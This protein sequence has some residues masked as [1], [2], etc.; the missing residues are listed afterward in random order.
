P[1]QDT[2]RIGSF[3]RADQSISFQAMQEKYEGFIQIIRQDPAVEAVSGF[4]GG[5]GQVNRGSIFITLKPLSERQT[6]ARDVVAR[7]QRA[8][9]KEPGARLTMMPAQDI[10]IGGRE[11]TAE[12]QYTLQADDIGELRTWEPQVRQ[13]LRQLPQITD[14][15]S[16]QDDRGAQTMLTIDRDAVARLGL[17]VAQVTA[18]LNDAFGQRQVSTI[19]NP[20]NQYQV[21]MTAA[22]PFA[23]SAQSLQNIY[24]VGRDGSRVPLSA[25]ASYETENTALSVNHQGQFVTATFSFNLAPGVALSEAA[26]AVHQAVARTGLP[27]S[28]IGSLQGTAGAFEKM[29]ATQVILILAALVVV[30]LV[31]GILYESFVHPLTI[32]STLPSAGIGALLAIEL[33][34]KDF[35]LITLL[36]VLLLIGLVMKNAIMMVDFALMAERQ[37]RMAPHDAIFT[38]CLLRF[39][40]IM[41]TTMTA[42][43]AALPL[44]LG[45]GDG[46]EL[47]QPLGLA[48][49]GGL[50]VSQL[51]TLY[52]TPVVYLYIYRLRER[53][54]GRKTVTGPLS[55]VEV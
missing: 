25:V 4:I 43:F 30:Y 51:L 29:A 16:D 37:Q 35:N 38:A 41:M 9:S 3:I 45:R 26:E 46:A 31:L 5:G 12:Y 47:R 28:V 55:S 22:P 2:G 13:A 44:M 39:R 15:D 34:G 40:P 32:L 14:V 53:L 6:S 17:T 54:T 24:L 42:I 36:G 52:T 7:L 1:T 49:V 48:I 21:V 18:A 10:R 8:L 50:L 19:Y 23:Q 11:A 20:L 27:V 33:L